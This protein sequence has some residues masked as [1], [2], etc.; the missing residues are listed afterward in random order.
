MQ[1]ED[2]F[3]LSSQALLYSVQRKTCVCRRLCLISTDTDTSP[4]LPIVHARAV[5]A[6]S[7][8]RAG[9]NAVMCT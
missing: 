9:S 6:G 2:D 3:R 1:L 8:I 5:T 7:A 4:L